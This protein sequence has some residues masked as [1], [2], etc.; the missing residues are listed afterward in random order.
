MGVG[1]SR[2]HGLPSE[3]HMIDSQRRRT[4]SNLYGPPHDTLQLCVCTLT[5]SATSGSTRVVSTYEARLATRSFSRSLLSP[6]H[7]LRAMWIA[8]SSLSLMPARGRE[9]RRCPTD[10]RV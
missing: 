1:H 7:R 3:M 2:R 4:L 6:T 10:M 9:G 8:E 5:A